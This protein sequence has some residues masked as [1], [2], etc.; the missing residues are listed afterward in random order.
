MNI[1]PCA[2]NTQRHPKNLMIPNI[3]WY[4]FCNHDYLHTSELAEVTFHVVLPKQLKSHGGEFDFSLKESKSFDKRGSRS[5]QSVIRSR[6]R[7]LIYLPSMM[8]TA[9]NWQCACHDSN[10]NEPCTGTHFSSACSGS[11]SLCSG[12]I[13][14][15]R[16]YSHAFFSPQH[17]SLSAVLICL[18]SQ[19]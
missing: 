9:G 6:A 4:Q 3:S 8:S 18:L 13:P 15:P 11:C 7:H 5:Y 19:A 16:A 2:C 10:L 12:Q 1:F 14:S 17:S